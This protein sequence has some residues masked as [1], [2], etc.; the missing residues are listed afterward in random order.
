M[1]AKKLTDERALSKAIDLAEPVKVK[2]TDMRTQKEIDISD[3]LVA[4]VQG[5]TLHQANYVASSLYYKSVPW[6]ELV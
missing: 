5:I 4:H 3:W 6:I 2:N 1:K